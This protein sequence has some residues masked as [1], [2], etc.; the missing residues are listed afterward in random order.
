VNAVTTRS[1]GTSKDNPNLQE[2]IQEYRKVERATL[3]S[4]AALEA[5]VDTETESEDS[6]S[7]EGEDRLNAP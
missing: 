4:P 2:A 1:K 3:T 5:E 7:L 6:S